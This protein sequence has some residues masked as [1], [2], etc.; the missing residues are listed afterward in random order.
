MPTLL[1]LDNYN[2]KETEFFTSQCVS[3][4]NILFSKTSNLNK[5]THV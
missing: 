3:L 1:Y 4:G 2:R 5:R